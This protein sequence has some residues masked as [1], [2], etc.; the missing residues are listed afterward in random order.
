MI[1]LLVKKAFKNLEIYD[2]ELIFFPLVLV[3]TINFFSF[4]FNLSY[5]DNSIGWITNYSETNNIFL[6]GR[7]AGFQGSGPNVAGTIFGL[8]TIL[9]FYFYRKTEKKIYIFLILLNLFLFIISYSRGSYLALI[10]V[11]I[12][13]VLSKIENSKIK[14]IYIS[15]I[16]I[17][18]LA[19]LYFGPSEIIL[20][21]NDRSL[22]ANIA[23]SNIEITNGVGG[24][25]YVEKIYETY[26]LS[27]DP[28]LLEEN[29][30][31]T[32][33]KV[34]LGITPE[35]YR[36]TDIEF[37]IG[38]SGGGFEILQQYFIVDQCSDDRN[39]C[40]YLRVDEDTVI[41]FLKI[42]RLPNQDLVQN[43][44]NKCVDNSKKL[45]TRGEFACLAFEL[46]VLGNNLN[47]Y[48]Y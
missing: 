34:E 6:S 25:K 43:A 47:F 37:F 36:D 18:S 20:K 28:D 22:L 14:T 8:L 27:V 13:Y 46:N 40:Q 42:F 3:S 29:L 39:T 32:L 45:I 1:G 10:L 21:E 11:S 19:L 12:I 31:I 33:N 44:I 5:L 48:D 35:E 2:F 38:T 17:S 26:L 23:I 41:N 4:L 9:S 16:L 24:G 30:K 15:G 7:L